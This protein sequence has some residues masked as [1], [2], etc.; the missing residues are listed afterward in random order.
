MKDVRTLLAEG[1][2]LRCE[3]GL[4]ADEAQRIRQTVLDA[5]VQPSAASAAWQRVAVVAAV[6][7][8][9]IAAGA[10]A[11][12][13]PA[14]MPSRTVDPDGL[15]PASEG[16]GERL[17]VQFATPGGTRIIW[18]IDPQFQVDEVIK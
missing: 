12:R 11:T 7:V 13:G 6:V 2:P 8:I 4:D 5:M 9:L 1:D 10:L 16:T 14:S 17:Q 18:T 15:A 3:P